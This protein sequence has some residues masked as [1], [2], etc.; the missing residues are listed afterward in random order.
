MRLAVAERIAE[1][2]RAGALVI[3]PS[4]PIGSPSLGEMGEKD[5]RVRELV[6]EYWP[7]TTSSAPIRAGR[8][9]AAGDDLGE[10]LEELGFGPDFSYSSGEELDVPYIHRIVG[11]H[12]VYFVSNQQDHDVTIEA[13]FRQAGGRRISLWDPATGRRSLPRE[14]GPQGRE[15]M[16]VTLDLDPHGSV[17]V[18]FSD[19]EVDTEPS[20]VVSDERPVE[21][22]WELRFPQGLGA[23]AEALVLDQLMDWSR[24]DESG[25][26]HF[27]GTASYRASLHFDNEDL[28]DRKH[29]LLDLGEVREMAEVLVNGQVAEILW[30]P[31]F[32][33]DITPLLS[34][35]E[36][37]LEIRVTNLWVNRLIGDEHYADEM[38]WRPIP[39]AA[40]PREWPEWI[41]KGE[42]R[43]DSDRVT[44]TTR[45]KIWSKDDPLLPSG[46][47]GPV[48]L[49]A[50]RET[51]D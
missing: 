18:V 14:V 17:F 21:G 33:T 20:L 35:G 11:D 15:G 19:R 42:P 6:A 27:S 46:L 23:P 45:G 7:E 5:R 50:A 49:L 41:K 38:E 34:A 36:N 40:L 26:R 32:R 29:I 24:R 8:V 12:D 43:P 31:P 44:W 16:Q 3:S 47:L 13:V 4:T 2:L 28:E 22:P 37:R 30:K 1:L 10:L 48:R 51:S 9:I 25:V 39:G